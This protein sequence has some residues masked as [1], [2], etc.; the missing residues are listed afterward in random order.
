PVAGL[1]AT[2]R[3]TLRI[4]LKHPDGNFA[5][6]LAFPLVGAVAR[7]VVEA[8]GDDTAS[9]PVGT[10]PFYLKEYT[11]S[12]RIVLEANPGFRGETWNYQAGPDAG[13]E[14]IVASMKGKRLPRIDRVEISIMEEAQSRWLAFQKGQTDIE[15]QVSELAPNFMTDDGRL[16]PEFAARGIK[17]DR[18]IDPEIIYLYFNVQERIGGQPNPVGGFTT[19]RI[20]LRRAIAMSYNI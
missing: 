3:H 13:D 1:E 17:L 7:E 12:S 15:A 18:S 14:E 6:V 2:D 5:H 10:G 9:H 19:E 8:Y 16:K 4:R 20:A 11:R